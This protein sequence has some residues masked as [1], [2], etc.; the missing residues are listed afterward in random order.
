MA[1]VR[2]SGR[3][4]QLSVMC[5]THTHTHPIISISGWGDVTVAAHVSGATL[6]PLRPAGHHHLLLLRKIIPTGC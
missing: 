4:L 5:S 2:V 3:L 1:T 6:P